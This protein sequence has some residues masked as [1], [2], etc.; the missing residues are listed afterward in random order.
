MS[1][2][3][4][5]TIPA[6]KLRARKANVEETQYLEQSQSTTCSGV[7]MS[8]SIGKISLFLILLVLLLSTK[9]ISELG[10]TVDEYLS[11]LDTFRVTHPTIAIPLPTRSSIITLVSDK[12]FYKTIGKLMPEIYALLHRSS[13]TCIDGIIPCW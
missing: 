2:G 5:E 8:T 6:V 1:T 7:K 4:A 12:N 11:R 10:Q 13:I 3:R 9:Y